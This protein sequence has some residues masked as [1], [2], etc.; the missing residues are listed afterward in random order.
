MSTAD[1]QLLTAASSVS[2][3][4]VEEFF[5][6]KLSV[7]TSMLVARGTVLVIALVG[8]VLAWNPDSSVFRIVSLPGL[9]ARPFGPVLL[10]ALFWKRSNKWGALAGMVSGGAMVFIWK[11][12]D[13]PHGGRME[14]L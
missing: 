1:S 7:K 2:Q 9:V 11:Y 8:L 6:V 5:G 4:L 13:C 12:L 3:N 10:C 14:H